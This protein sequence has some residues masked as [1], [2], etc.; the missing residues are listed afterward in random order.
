MAKKCSK[1]ERRDG[2]GDCRNYRH[3]YDSYHGTAAQRRNRAMRNHARATLEQSGMV[4]KGDGKEVDHKRPL[5][6]G[7]SNARSNLQVLTRS[8]NRRK[9]SK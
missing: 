5:D 2:D 8:A 9:G 3:E 4:R 1:G 7:G 6:K